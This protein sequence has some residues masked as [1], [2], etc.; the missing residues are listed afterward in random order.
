LKLIAEVNYGKITHL[1]GFNGI[2]PSTVS[3]VLHQKRILSSE[4]HTAYMHMHMLCFSLMATLDG[5]LVFM[6]FN[7]TVT[8]CRSY[9]VL[10]SHGWEKKWSSSIFLAFSQTEQKPIKHQTGQCQPQPESSKYKHSA[11]LLSHLPTKRTLTW[12]HTILLWVTSVLT[13][14]NSWIWM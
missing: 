9:L 5:C 8:N 10:S 14:V 11:C 6:L 12:V 3:N 7:G 1:R 4:L 13:A 2:H